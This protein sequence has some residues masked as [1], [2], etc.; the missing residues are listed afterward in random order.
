MTLS[1]GALLHQ[2]RVNE[3]TPPLYFVI[4]WVWTK[5]FGS[6]EVGLRSLSAFLGIAVIPVTYLCGK[7][8]VSRAAG[9]VAA[10]FAAFSPFMI[11]YSQ[12]ARSY[13]L[14]GLLSGASLL[15]CAR[16]WREPSQRNLFLWAG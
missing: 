6:G 14:F 15:L 13:M 5:L 2:V 7:E 10:A 3:T 4:A 1:F 16:A 12:E 11:W 8:L 9:L